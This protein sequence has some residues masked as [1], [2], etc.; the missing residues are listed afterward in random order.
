[1][2]NVDGERGHKQSSTT[3][4]NLQVKITGFRHKKGLGKDKTEISKL[5]VNGLRKTRVSC[6][7]CPTYNLRNRAGMTVA[8]GNLRM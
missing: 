1:M 6:V 7:H 5:R 3:A 2:Y 8:A 4:V